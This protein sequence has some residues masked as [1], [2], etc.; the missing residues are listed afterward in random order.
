MTPSIY[1]RHKWLTRLKSTLSLALLS[2]LLTFSSFSFAQTLAD[3]TYTITSRF[4]G[5]VIDVAGSS[6]DDGA[7]IQLYSDWGG[8]NQKWNVTNLGN[9]YYSIRAV[10]SGKSMDVFEWCEEPGCE[11]R[12]WEY[13]GGNNQ[14]W[15]IVD[16]GSGYYKI[17]SRYNG[18][19]L[20]VWE[21]NTGDGADLRQWSDTGGNNQQW[22]FTPVGGGSTGGGETIFNDTWWKDN[23]NNPIFSQGGGV[24]KVG[25]TYYWYG[26]EYTGAQ[27]YYDNPGAGKRNNDVAFASVNTYSSQDLVNWELEAKDVLANPGGWFGRLGVAYNDNTN[28]YVLVSQT[29]NPTDGNAMYFATSDSPAGGFEFSNIQNNLAG[30]VNG[31]TGDQTIFIDDDGKAYVVASSLNGRSNRYIIPLRESDYLRVEDPIYVYGGNGREGNTM[32]KHEGTYYFCSSDLHGWNTSQTYCVS[33]QSIYGPWSSEFV[34]EGSEKDYSHVTQAGFFIKVNGTEKTTIIYAGD[35]WADFAG[36]GIGYNQWVPISFNGTEPYF[37]SLSAWTLNATTGNWSVAPENNYVLNPSFEADRIK[38]D[39]PR[40]WYA[41]NAWPS[42]QV[43]GHTGKWSWDISGSGWMYHNVDSLPNGTCDL[44][45]WVSQSSGGELYVKNHGGSEMSTNI[46]S[47]S[48]WT[49]VTLQNIQVTAGTAEIGVRANGASLRVDDFT[50]I[51]SGHDF[52]Y[53]Q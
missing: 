33:S 1:K 23:S 43:E 45:V 35:R 27:L 19:P 34:M 4:S 20:D 7:N 12:Q 8:D 49:R 41:S 11:I 50:M 30:V 38:V 15:D 26:V 47:S 40:G 18:L 6:T 24:L 14:Q 32:F 44:S 31:A 21:L 51:L 28:K 39:E 13:L 25:D 3:G 46:P 22:S 16:V 10:H 9:G 5:K 36:N 53:Y 48:G 52:P 37:N 17:V 29:W 42:D 2:T